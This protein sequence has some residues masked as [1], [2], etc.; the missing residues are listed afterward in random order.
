MS[1][2]QQI[3]QALLAY[4][5]PVEVDGLWRRFQTNVDI[6][7]MSSAPDRVIRCLRHDY[8]GDDSPDDG[9]GNALTY[10]D[11]DLLASGVAIKERNN[12]L[13]LN[14]DLDG[15]ANAIVPL[16]TA[17]SEPPFDLLTANG[18]LSGR[19]PVCAAL[20]DG[21]LQDAIHETGTL[22]VTFSIEDLEI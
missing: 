20:H 12:T 21:A 13:T 17:P 19:L 11:E 22:L 6:W 14:S 7:S 16:R 18:T 15:P 3:Y 10:S 8:S 1:I 4:C 2:H 5:Q 9:D